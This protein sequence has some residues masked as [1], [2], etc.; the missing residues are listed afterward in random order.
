MESKSN[1]LPFHGTIAGSI[2]AVA[3]FF[4]AAIPLRADDCQKRIISAD[5]KLHEAAQHHGW[6]SP[7]TQRYRQEL[8]DARTFCWNHGHRWWNE[9]DHMWHTERDWDVHDHDH[10]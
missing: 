10:D 2:L 6:D 3:L 8:M 1:L 4:V 7:E 5:H 9:D